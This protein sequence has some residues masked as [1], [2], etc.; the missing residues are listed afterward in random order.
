MHF[1]IGV[2]L[3]VVSGLAFWLA[4]PRDGQVRSFLR[5]DRAQAYYTVGMLG[6]LIG[7]ML[8]LV[9]GLVAVAE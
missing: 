5:S 2:V 4:F 1:V 6:A 7:G 9:L 3:V 8:N